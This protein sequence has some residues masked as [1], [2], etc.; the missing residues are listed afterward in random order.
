VIRVGILGTGW[1]AHEHALALFGMPDVHVGAVASQDQGRADRFAAAH[2]IPL[3][4]GSYAELL[5]G[6]EVDVVHV[7]TRPVHHA[8]LA[9][10]ALLEGTH[11][12]AEKPLTRS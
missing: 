4:R 7:C 12:V 9:E 5:G 8:E 11:V 6:T 2:D 10:R 3:A 1:I